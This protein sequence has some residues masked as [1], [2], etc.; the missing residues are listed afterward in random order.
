MADKLLSI[1]SDS[2]AA[3]SSDNRVSTQR[4]NELEAL[5]GPLAWWVVISHILPIVGITEETLGR[6]GFLVEGTYAVE[7]FIIMSG[8]FIFYLLDSGRENYKQFI[9]RRF[10]RLYPAYFVCL[11][12]SILSVGIS[13]EALNTLSW[14]SARNAVRIDILNHSLDYFLHHL[15]AHLT[16]LHGVIPHSILPSSS[17]A[18]IGQAWSI[19]LEWQ[20]YL[21]APL[22]F[23]IIKR[24][25]LII[26]ISTFGILCLVFYFFRNAEK[27]FLLTQIPFF[28]IGIFSFYIWKN[29]QTILTIP[30][31]Y[32]VFVTPIS[33]GLTAGFTRQLSTTLWVL[34]FLSVLALRVN[35][36][37]LLEKM[38][39]KILNNRIM[40]YFGNIS[41][42]IYLCHM[43]VIYSTLFC[44][45]QI[46]PEHGQG[47]YLVALMLLVIPLTT[48]FSHFLHYGIEKPFMRLGKQFATK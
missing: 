24:K 4:I 48:I 40:L 41:Y 37:L 10:F 26:T 14:E 8:F 25:N 28:V 38:L 31:K 23:Q 17:Y 7:V 18:F 30:A 2:I 6:F 3:I 33:V 35:K 15:I 27:A 43:I 13:L 42:S 1:S 32:W 47:F 36:K 46:A 11:I 29:Y 9:I 45:T 39:S 20:F 5:R 44:V 21:V 16:M 22:L 19:S 34:V 12:I